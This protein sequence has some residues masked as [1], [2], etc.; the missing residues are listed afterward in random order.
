[1]KILAVASVRVL[2]APA[3]KRKIFKY[4]CR[5]MRFAEIY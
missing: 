3:K 1:M 5:G 2:S 4:I